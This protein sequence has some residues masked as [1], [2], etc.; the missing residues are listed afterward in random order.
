MTTVGFLRLQN[1]W[2]DLWTVAPFHRWI[3]WKIAVQC[4]LQSLNDLMT[5]DLYLLQCWTALMIV[6]LQR[7]T[8]LMT[9]VVRP[10]LQG[11]TGLVDLYLL[12]SDDHPLRLLELCLL[13]VQSGTRTIVVL[14]YLR[15]ETDHL[16][17]MTIDALQHLRLF[18]TGQQGLKTVGN[19]S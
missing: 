11:V 9:D 4:L 19:L 5:V 16:L 7:W 17:P 15:L 14:Q 18:W 12:M 10:L 1:V 3:D 6:D 8:D 2:T 13:S